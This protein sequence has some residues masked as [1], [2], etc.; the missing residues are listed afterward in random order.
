MCGIVGLLV[1]NP[2]MRPRLGSLLLPMFDCMADRGPDSA[3]LAVFTDPVDRATRKFSLYSDDREYNWSKLA[4]EFQNQSKS[5]AK[6]D[7]IENHAT[8][9]SSVLPDSLKAWLVQ[10]DS[11]LH[12]L[13]AGR[14]ID[15]YKDTGHPCEIAKRY[16]FGRLSASH[17]VGHTR[18]ATESA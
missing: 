14:S 5:P 16:H 6:V 15:V 4:Q 13:S 10:Y 8:L 9:V 3:G 2:A 7:A 17:C 11:K 18:M 12:L 1:K